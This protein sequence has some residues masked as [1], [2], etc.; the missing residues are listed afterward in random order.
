MNPRKLLLAF[1]QVA[2]FLL[3]VWLAV[4][5]RNQEP[6]HSHKVK[7]ELAAGTDMFWELHDR[8]FPAHYLPDGRVT[9][10]EEQAIIELEKLGLKIER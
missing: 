8:H 1:L 5:I 7:N 10:T 4:L 2:V 9:C 3:T 6:R